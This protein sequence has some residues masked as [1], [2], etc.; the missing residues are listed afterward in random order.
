MGLRNFW[1]DLE[2]TV[3]MFL[4]GL[5]VSLWDDN[6][7]ASQS[8][9]FVYRWVLRVLELMFFFFLLG[10]QESNFSEFIGT[11]NQTGLVD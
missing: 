4:M 8:L 10:L 3:Y 11:P 9:K 5:K 6:N 2:I 1:P 7:I